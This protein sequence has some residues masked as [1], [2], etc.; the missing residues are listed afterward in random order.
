MGKYLSWMNFRGQV[1]GKTNPEEANV[2][3]LRKVFLLEWRGLGLSSCPNTGDNGAHGSASPFEA[4]AERVNWLG[5]PIQDDS[6]GQALLACGMTP[7]IIQHCFS[8]PEV[9][10]PPGNLPQ[11]LF[12]LLEDLD[13]RACLQRL[14][15]IVSHN[16]PP[17]LGM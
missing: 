8:D 13:S 12:D 2:G 10:Y 3:S 15:D 17:S 16:F 5:V 6:Y 9:S 4:L 1:L 7:Q 11:S 14:C